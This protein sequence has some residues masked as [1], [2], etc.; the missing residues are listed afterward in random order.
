MELLRSLL[1]A[2][3]GTGLMSR[4]SFTEM[5]WEGRP[6]SVVPGQAANQ[7]LKILGVPE[8]AGRGLHPLELHALDPRRV[9]GRGLLPARRRRRPQPR[10]AGVL[11]ILIVW[12]SEQIYL[13]LL[14]LG[15]PWPWNLAHR[16]DAPLIDVLNRDRAS[17]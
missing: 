7:I 6:A 12:G 1:A 14:G 8:I 4:S 10:R 13:P 9:V 16:C 17:D 5:Y 2:F 3:I 15:I 11:F